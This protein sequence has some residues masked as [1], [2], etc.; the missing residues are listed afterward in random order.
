VLEAAREEHRTPAPAVVAPEL[1]V[2]ALA[3]HTGDDVPDARSRVE[4]VKK[5]QFGLLCFDRKEAKRAAGGNG[6]GNR[7]LSVGEVYGCVVPAVWD[8]TKVPRTLSPNVWH[9]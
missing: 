4:A 8:L 3:R 6:R 7:E 5:A 1:E 9:V 2:V